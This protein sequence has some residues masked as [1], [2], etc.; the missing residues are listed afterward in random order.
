[1]FLEGLR[2]LGKSARD[3]SRGRCHIN[4][5]LHITNVGRSSSSSVARAE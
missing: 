4:E 1:M 5:A 2:G 3:T